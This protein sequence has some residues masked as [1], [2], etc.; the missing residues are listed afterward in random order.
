MWVLYHLRK[1]FA[2][3]ALFS[4][5]RSLLFARFVQVYVLKN[6]RVHGTARWLDY[7]LLRFMVLHPA[8]RYLLECLLLLLLSWLSVAQ[9]CP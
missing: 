5:L 2:G 1:A 4:Q 7:Y 8:S 9:L 6:F 3:Q